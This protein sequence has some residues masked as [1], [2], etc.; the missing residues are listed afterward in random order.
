MKNFIYIGL[1]L[2]AAACN[3]NDHPS[4]NLLVN[5]SAEVP[6]YDSIPPGWQNVQGHWVT[7]EGDST[8]HDF[9]FAKE[10]HHYFF[11][12]NDTLGVLQQDV[13]VSD[14]ADGIDA[15]K[16]SF[17]FSGYAQSLDQGPNS[18]QAM[19][20]IKG[21]DNSKNKTLYTFISD[22]TRSIG[23]WLQVRDSFVAPI[24][25]RFIR[26]QLI[27]IRHVGGDNDGYFDNILLTTKST[28]S[29]FDKKWLFI[30][31]AIVLVIAI[32]FFIYKKRKRG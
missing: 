19:I 26:V 25:T 7:L 27:A 18:D 21:L 12:G 6:K 2:L 22:T 9:G 10:G 5:G 20:T 1:V 13:N 32:G 23:K 30:A 11:A 29:A 15:N 28:G 16:Q 4:L 14:Y 31:I 24:S 3:S 17:V 8:H